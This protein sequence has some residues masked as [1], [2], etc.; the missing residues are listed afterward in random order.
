MVMD[1]KKV[2]SNQEK[3]LY[4]IFFVFGIA[5][6][7]LI[8]SIWSRYNDRDLITAQHQMQIVNNYLL[9]INPNDTTSIIKV[10]ENLIDSRDNAID[11]A[12]YSIYSRNGE[13]LYST[14]SASRNQNILSFNSIDEKFKNSPVIINKSITS[15]DD[16]LQ[17]ENVIT[18]SYS[19]FY[20]RFIISECIVID[21]TNFSGFIKTM[22]KK[23][24]L[25]MIL[26]LAAFVCMFYLYR[27]INNIARLRSYILKLNDE[28]DSIHNNINCI[29]IT[30][31]KNTEEFTDDLYTLY[32][33][34]ID[35]IK[36]ND[37]ERERAVLEEKNKLYSKRILANNLNH[38]I[39]TPIGIIIGYLDTLINIPDIDDETRLEFLKKCLTNTQRLQ[40]MVVN[41][42]MLNRIEDGGNNIALENI[43][44]YN[45]ANSA[46]EDLKFTLEEYRMKFHIE[47]D[48]DTIIKGNEIL[49]YNIFC[50]LLK[51]CCYYSG[52]TNI[53][54][55]SMGINNGLHE[56][57]FK[58]DGKGVPEE[59]LSKLFNR[60]YRV[61]KDKNKKSGTGLGLP[62]I[63][64]S[65]NLS[66]GSI[67]A[68]NSSTGGLEFIFSLPIPED[69]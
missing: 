9:S 13:L 64:E 35:I 24:I 41:I 33:R 66:G 7:S 28:V 43:N 49:L 42:A 57:S 67:K 2:P 47:I 29:N 56:F 8:G 31:T 34:Q 46:K 37:I 55:K 17:K 16:I 19:P 60:F 21:K 30:T 32:K 63:K 27:Y 39:K 58:D 40:N 62:I 52:G 18:T 25:I 59:S 20:D 38:E 48:K 26:F 61:E 44:I 45:I 65:I 68:Q 10:T 69:K 12:F 4:G 15:Y 36:Q 5:M 54:L 53:Y 23:I 50:N 14:A 22:S 3:A 6:L 1:F 11:K 51:N